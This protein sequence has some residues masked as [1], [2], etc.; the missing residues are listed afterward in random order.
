MPS[1]RDA[2]LDKLIAH[3]ESAGTDAE[4]EKRLR[5]VYRYMYHNVNHLTLTISE[6]GWIR[7]HFGDLRRFGDK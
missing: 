6:F 4:A 7:P 5:E 1:V 3:M 2:A